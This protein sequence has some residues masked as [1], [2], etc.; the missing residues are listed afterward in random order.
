MFALRGQLFDFAADG[1]ISFDHPA[2]GL[3]R[4]TMNGF[5][6]FAH[7]MRPFNMLILMVV[8]R[9]SNQRALGLEKRWETATEDLD[10][11][12]KQ[13]VIE[14]R[15]AMETNGALYAAP[16]L[17]PLIRLAFAIARVR[18][19]TAKLRSRLASQE[20]LIDSMAMTAGDSNR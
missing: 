11:P 1:G 9:G 8:V 19:G 15:K 20:A 18:I 2:Y 14:F 13:V 12:T 17:R 3:L 7:M 10:D 4:S 5:I 6:R 16:W